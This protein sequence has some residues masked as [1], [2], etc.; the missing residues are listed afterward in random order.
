M[1]GERTFV[2]KF[3]SDVKDAIKG[4]TQMNN[5]FARFSSNVEDRVMNSLK[6]L[7]PSFKQVS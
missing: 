2:V 6:G 7:I 1:A 4:V 3:V 5:S